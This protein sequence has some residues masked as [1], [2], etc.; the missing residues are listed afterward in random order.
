MTDVRGNSD[1]NGKK[2]RPFRVL[3]GF[4]SMADELPTIDAAMI[5]ARALEAD[6]T[7]CF[8]EDADLLNLAALPFAKAIRPSDRSVLQIEREQM[9]QQFSRA[10]SNW[11]RTL[12]ARSSHSSVRCSFKIMHGAYSTE[13]AREAVASDIVVIN[14][15]NLPYRAPNAASLLWHAID[16]A[17]G[18]VIM[19]ERSQ[20]LPNGP[21]VLLISGS[22][23]DRSVLTIANRIARAT[24]NQTVILT[25]DAAEGTRQ[26]IRDTAFEIFA[27]EADIRL[28]AESRLETAAVRI[29]ELR[30]SFVILQP[31][32]TSLSDASIALLLNSSQAP[33]MLMRRG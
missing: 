3:A 13:I 22:N 1:K 16:E 33:L 5:L 2:S 4:G 10:A 24:G 30:P 18:M 28:V 9:E 6:I 17:M 8:V 12:F 21:V 15:L 25:T 29:A 32:K 19:P 26:Q 14:P 31:S 27:S 23:A 7:G 11:Q 20:W